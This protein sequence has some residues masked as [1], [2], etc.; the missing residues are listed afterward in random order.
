MAVSGA[1]LGV[2]LGSHPP[3]GVARPSQP[4]GPH[5]YPWRVPVRHSYTLGQLGRQPSRRDQLTGLLPGLSQALGRKMRFFPQVTGLLCLCLCSAA[6]PGPQENNLH[7][8]CEIRQ[9]RPLSCRLLY[10]YSHAEC[11]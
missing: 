10:R 3:G 6:R 11:F 5:L 2:K 1:G 4:L 9:E 7:H 8:N